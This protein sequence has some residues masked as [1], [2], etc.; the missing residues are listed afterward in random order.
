MER[1]REVA[2]PRDL[3][4]LS[5][6]GTRV[7]M[8]V[9]HPYGGTSAQTLD[10]FLDLIS[11]SALSSL[12]NFFFSSF[13]GGKSMGSLFKV[14]IKRVPVSC[15]AVCRSSGVRELRKSQRK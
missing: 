3:R 8:C 9:T 10:T 6:R 7:F 1:Q 15:V 14:K 4:T 5:P 11:G 13:R 12:E 2:R